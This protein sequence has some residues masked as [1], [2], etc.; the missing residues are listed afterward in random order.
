MKL[1]SN[2]VGLMALCMVLYVSQVFGK[3]YDNNSADIDPS[4]ITPA[5]TPPMNTRHKKNIDWKNGIIFGG[6]KAKKPGLK[7]RITETLS[8]LIKRDLLNYGTAYLNFDVEW[9]ETGTYKLKFFPFYINFNWFNLRTD[10]VLVDVEKFAFN[11]T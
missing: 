1:R 3:R 2:I 7:V 6:L 8:A 4:K 5:Y 9:P 11:F 10:P